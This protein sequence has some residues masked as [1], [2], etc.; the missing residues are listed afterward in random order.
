MRFFIVFILFLISTFD[1]SFARQPRKLKFSP[2]QFKPPEVTQKQ[3]TNGTTLF[4]L[5]DHELPLVQITAYIGTGSM[6]DKEDRAGVAVL[7]SSLLRSGGTRSSKAETIDEELE[8][9]GASVETGMEIEFGAISLSVLKK[10]LDKGLEI[11]AD[12]LMHPTFNKKKLAIEKARTIEQIRRRNDEPFQIARREFR[13]LIYGY[14]HPLSRTL[15]IPVIK[16]ISRKELIEFHKKYYGPDNMRIAISG[17]FNS[18]EMIQK[19]ESLFKNWKRVSVSYPSVPTVRPLESLPSCRVG[20]AE[21]ELNQ[22]SIIIGKLGVKRHDPDRFILE[23]M[24]EILGGNSFTSR[25]YKEVRSKQGLA[26]WI[27][28]SFSEPWDYG[29]FAVGCQTKSETVGQ[30]I[31]SILKEIETIREK[32][33]TKEEVQMAKD[34]IINSFVFRYASSHAIA[35]EKMSLDYFGFPSDYL[36]SYTKKISEV[37]A[38]DVL[39]VAKKTVQPD[40]LTFLVVGRQRNFDQPLSDFG[41]VQV[42]DLKIPE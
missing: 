20:Y 38:Q 10:D 14:S 26:Y 12:C 34:S 42:I 31:Q 30:V 13:K 2:L 25:L 6:Y 15:E 11:F 33:V 22:A 18:E 29:T 4:L 23:V 5:P 17:D 16:K 39:R 35:V 28:S 37:T 24:N 19:L 3:L 36:N 40:L 7:C 32:K 8:F 27:G 1:L 41:K 9:L 21:K